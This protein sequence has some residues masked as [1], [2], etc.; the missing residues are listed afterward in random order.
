[1][2]DLDTIEATEPGDT[3]HERLKARPDSIPAPGQMLGRYIV[4]GILGR[5][6]MGTV[7]KAYDEALDRPVALKLLHGGTSD[8]HTQRLKR[9]AQALA[10]LSHPNVVQVYEVGEAGNQW[11]IAMELVNGQT[12][13][14]W[15][16]A[17]R[18]W[19]ARVNVY[20]EV[21][22]G[23]A[24]AHA[25]GLVHRDFKPDNCIID[26]QGRPRVLDFGLVR[27]TDSARYAPWIA[28][29]NG[30]GARHRDLYAPRAA[31]R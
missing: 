28:H 25:A 16:E 12:L 23:L 31:Q 17:D 27:E 13:R 7:L 19:Q 5:G 21:G 9:E 2:P 3:L 29:A 15:Q 26:E 10:K 8:H 22:R 24:A 20:L 30:S 11:F 18:R 1:M 4:I 14:E 6:G